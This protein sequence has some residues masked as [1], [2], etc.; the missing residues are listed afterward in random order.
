MKAVH[1]GSGIV[2]VVVLVCG[3]VTAHMNPPPP[4]AVVPTFIGAAVVTGLINI[5]TYRHANPVHEN[6]INISL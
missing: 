4:E 3:I 5:V 2:F 6:D 1:I